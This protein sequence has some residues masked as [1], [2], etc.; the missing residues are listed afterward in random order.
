MGWGS[1][2]TKKSTDQARRHQ[3]REAK[4]RD[5]SSTRNK[6]A[7]AKRDKA[8]AARKAASK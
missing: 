4:K 1:Q 6:I 7:Q 2:T 5:P 3:E 8:K